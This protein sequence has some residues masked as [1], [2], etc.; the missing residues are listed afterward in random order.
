MNQ[1]VVMIFSLG[2][3]AFVFY[4]QIRVRLVSNDTKLMIPLIMLVLG[5]YIFKNYMDTNS[6]TVISWISILISLSILAIGMA[7]FRATTVKIWIDKG[8]V[9]RQGTWITVA[10]WVVSIAVHLVLNQIGH[11][12]QSTSL[13]YF[14]VT[15]TVQKLIVQKRASRIYSM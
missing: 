8:N 4:N 5:I 15:F 14:V 2:M 12:G 1:Y 11:V 9:Y 13:I 7:A 6:L 3:A 10:L